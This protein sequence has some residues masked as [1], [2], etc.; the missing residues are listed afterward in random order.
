M[1]A[2]PSMCLGAG[3]YV[4]A[5]RRL[6]VSI[7]RLQYR[8]ETVFRDERFARLAAR[9]APVQGSGEKV[10]KLMKPMTRVARDEGSG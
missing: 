6:D 8:G 4:A 2:I 3:L 10:S 5:A 1:L 9:E 7:G